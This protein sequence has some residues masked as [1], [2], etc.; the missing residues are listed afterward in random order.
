ME[1]QAKIAGYNFCKS[2]T[3]VHTLASM[4]F[5]LIQ[6][7]ENHHNSP[8]NFDLQSFLCLTLILSVSSKSLAYFA[9]E[10]SLL[11]WALCFSPL[12]KKLANTALRHLDIT[13]R[14]FMQ[15]D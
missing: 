12:Q 8:G 7:T 2:V 3:G 6:T 5:H 11:S 10:A 15:I 13:M 4:A 1:V 14:C 9:D